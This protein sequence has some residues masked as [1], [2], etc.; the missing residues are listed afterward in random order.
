MMIHTNK[1]KWTRR[2]LRLVFLKHLSVL[3]TYHISRDGLT[4]IHGD[5]MND[6]D[7]SLLKGEGPKL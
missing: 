2:H 6:W 3:K 7:P 4:G 5:G 1:T